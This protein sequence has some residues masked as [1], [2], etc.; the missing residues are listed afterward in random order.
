[1]DSSHSHKQSPF[2]PDLA[3]SLSWCLIGKIH[4][5]MHSLKQNQEKTPKQ[6]VGSFCRLNGKT[7]NKYC[8]KSTVPI[9]RP[10]M[11]SVY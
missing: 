6:P 4:L 9:A 5:K 7:T 10:L 1:M 2:M 3:K 8:V 11:K